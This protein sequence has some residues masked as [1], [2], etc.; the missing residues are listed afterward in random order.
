M[1]RFFLAGWS[2][3][4]GSLRALRPPLASSGDIFERLI[5]VWISGQP[6]GSVKAEDS[7]EEVV[8]D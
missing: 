8:K 1:S 6:F 4:R 5:G 2:R 7:N 3:L